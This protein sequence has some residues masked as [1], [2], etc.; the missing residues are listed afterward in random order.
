MG[1]PFPDTHHQRRLAG[2]VQ[3]LIVTTFVQAPPISD[4]DDTTTMVVVVVAAA[5]VAVHVVV[6]AV[7]VVV[8]VVTFQQ[9][10][11]QC[12]R[13]GFLPRATVGVG[14]GGGDFGVRNVV[15]FPDISR[16]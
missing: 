9:R 3:Y 11:P 8:L 7:V 10:H 12:Q 13:L 4:D 16:C 1:D 14:G 6:G 2:R 15:G 5:V